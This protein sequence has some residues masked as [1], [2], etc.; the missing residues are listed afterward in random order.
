MD[1][2]QPG[3]GIVTERDISRAV[4][5]GL[6]PGSERV[7]DHTSTNAAYATPDWPLDEAVDSMRDGGFR[8]LVV[9]DGTEL[10]GIVSMRD[11]VRRWSEDRRG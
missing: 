2:D 8:H 6:D 1:P 5:E 11:V 7:G 10:V 4:G 3:P 9:I